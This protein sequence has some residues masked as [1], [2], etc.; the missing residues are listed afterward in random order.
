M[1]SWIDDI[2][3]PSNKK[4]SGEV[5]YISFMFVKQEVSIPVSRSHTPGRYSLPTNPYTN[6]K[7]MYSR[8][9]YFGKTKVIVTLF[10]GSI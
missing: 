4:Y 6:S 1:K 2:L 3:F 8:N 10:L 5:P 7:Y 9:T